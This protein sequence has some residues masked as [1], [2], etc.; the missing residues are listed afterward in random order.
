MA[1]IRQSCEPRGRRPVSKRTLRTRSRLS[2][3]R[4]RRPPD[5]VSAARFDPQLLFPPPSR[6]QEAPHAPAPREVM[7]GG[8][9]HVLRTLCPDDEGCLISFFN[10]HTEETVFQRYGYHV[11]EM[12]HEWARH[13]VGV[14]QSRDLALGVFE[15]GSDG[16][17]V[18]HAV[19]RYLLDPDGRS[20][21]MAFVVRE[22]KRRLGICTAL[23]R[24]L[25]R[26][27]RARGLGYLHAQVQSDNAAMLG[28]FRRHGGRSR[29]ISGAGSVEMYVPT[30]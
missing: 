1:N 27:A 12:T 28:I 13:L 20:A 2:R 24:T 3:R 8:L 4:V 14:D 22:T 29:P 11:G 19:G 9:P 26:A 25:L 21:E 18:L 17:E 23:L 10:S 16:G 15:R 7:F 5:A 30:G 6:G